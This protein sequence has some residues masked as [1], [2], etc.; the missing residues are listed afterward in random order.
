[1]LTGHHVILHFYIFVTVI[2]LNTTH[3]TATHVMWSW[4]G[5]PKDLIIDELILNNSFVHL[6]INNQALD[7][8]FAP[9][10]PGEVFKVYGWKD[11]INKLK[12]LTNTN[13]Y[14]CFL[15]SSVIILTAL[16]AL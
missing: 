15:F 10:S 13:N 6:K 1:M 9:V 5:S 8:A 4:E 12:Y 2:V 14:L 7:S 16:I 3:D 11:S